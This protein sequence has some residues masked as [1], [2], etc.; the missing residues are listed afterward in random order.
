VSR[1]K[2]LQDGNPEQMH[3][4]GFRIHK[5]LKGA[6]A[7]ETEIKQVY[8]K[9]HIHGDWY[10]VTRPFLTEGEECR[11]RAFCGYCKGLINAIS[12]VKKLRRRRQFMRRIT[13]ASWADQL[14]LRENRPNRRKANRQHQ[15]V[16]RKQVGIYRGNSAPWD[17]DNEVNPKIDL[18]M[19]LRKL[20][21]RGE[22]LP[23]SKAAPSTVGFVRN[24]LA[25]FTV[26]SPPGARGYQV[27]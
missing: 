2:R 25:S 24:T 26:F 3:L 1:L 5:T 19:F 12:R 4:E 23:T 11:H 13:E 7:H 8:D 15:W 21:T 18:K 22:R 16:R 6:T 14:V 27:S 20:P 9:S 17:E 10:A